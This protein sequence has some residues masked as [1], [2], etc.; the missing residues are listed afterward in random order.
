MTETAVLWFRRDLRLIDSHAMY[1]LEQWLQEDDSRKWIAFFH[2]E[3][4]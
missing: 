4:K 1:A 2:I 3:E